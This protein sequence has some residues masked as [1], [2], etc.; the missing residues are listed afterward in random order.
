MQG[1]VS[2]APPVFLLGGSQG[3]LT[4]AELLGIDRAP[5]CPHVGMSGVRPPP[6]WSPAPLSPHSAQ[7]NTLSTAGVVGAGPRRA[8]LP[9]EGRSQLPIGT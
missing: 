2:W 3:A 5:H 6:L 1:N 7:R 9:A 4:R 8:S